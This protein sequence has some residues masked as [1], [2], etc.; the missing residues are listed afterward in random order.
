MCIRDSLAAVGNC[1]FG[2][3]QP[4]GANMKIFWSGFPGPCGGANTECYHTAK[5]LREGGV[6][7]TFL[8]TGGH[9]NSFRE[10]LLA[11]GCGVIDAE[12]GKMADVP[13]LQG[14]P[15]ISMCNSFFSN[16]GDEFR[17][18]GCATAWVN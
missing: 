11:I 1:V 4:I 18:M 9:D 3:L 7:L 2:K 12:W 14:S 6:D 10:K 15:V 5:M 16:H 17:E 8:P 13:G